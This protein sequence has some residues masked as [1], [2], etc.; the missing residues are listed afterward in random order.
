MATIKTG[1][2]FGVIAL[3]LFWPTFPSAAVITDIGRPLAKIFIETEVVPQTP[4]IHAM[5][6]YRVRV[7]HAVDLQQGQLEDPIIETALIEALDDI[8]ITTTQR[9]R[10][11]YRVIERNYAIFPQ[12]I[13]PLT[14]KG[15]LLLGRTPDGPVRIKGPAVTAEVRPPPE[16]SHLPWIPAQKLEF[17]ESW[18]EGEPPKFKVGEP[19]T[20]IVT[21]KV[22]GLM[23]T[24]LPPTSMRTHTEIRSYPEQPQLETTRSTDTVFATQIERFTLVARQAGTITLPEIRIPWFDV[25]NERMEQ[26]VIAARTINVTS[27][28]QVAADQGLPEP[29]QPQVKLIN[30]TASNKIKPTAQDDDGWF[31]LA[32]GL[33]LLWLMTLLLWWHSRRVKHSR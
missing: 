27:M 11:R 13:G 14:I 33:G 2:I 24:Q 25:K 12:Q 9:G 32:I 7:F 21:L 23:A 5:L 1:W 10:Q 30:K 31:F 28:S 29:T 6:R 18:P 15:P 19:Q 4:F 17:T 8:S 16:D 22:T 20:R 3:P 26:A